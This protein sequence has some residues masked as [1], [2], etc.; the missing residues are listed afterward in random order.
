METGVDL[1]NDIY[2]RVSITISSRRMICSI[3]CP[4]CKILFFVLLEKQLKKPFSGGGERGKKVV[5][6]GGEEEI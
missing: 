1:N 3:I 6:S 4:N 2:K 5:E